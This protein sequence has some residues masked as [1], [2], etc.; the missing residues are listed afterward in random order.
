VHKIRAVV[1]ARHLR[2]ETPCVN[3]RAL[4]CNAVWLQCRN[5]R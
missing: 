1:I 2:P 3:A 4:R 5:V